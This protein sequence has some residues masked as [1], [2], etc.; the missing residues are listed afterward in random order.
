MTS[1]QEQMKERMNSRPDEYTIAW[2]QRQMG[3][4]TKGYRG[5]THF[6]QIMSNENADL[7]AAL[8]ELKEF[9]TNTALD[10]S[11]IEAKVGELQ[12][13]MTKLQEALKKAREAYGALKKGTNADNTS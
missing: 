7:H 9:A 12:A 13:E 5:A 3:E 8:K 4:V 1:I 6:M 10:L 2:W 11:K